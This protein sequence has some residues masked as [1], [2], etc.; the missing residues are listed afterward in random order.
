VLKRELLALASN[1]AFAASNFSVVGRLNNMNAPRD[2]SI[3]AIWSRFN[4]TIISSIDSRDT[5]R[6][7]FQG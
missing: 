4:W 5:C 3:S 1:L 6:F 7:R 2:I